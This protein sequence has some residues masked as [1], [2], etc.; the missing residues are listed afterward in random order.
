MNKKEARSPVTKAKIYNS[1]LIN[2]ECIKNQSII[3]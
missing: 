1:I 3:K 2:Q